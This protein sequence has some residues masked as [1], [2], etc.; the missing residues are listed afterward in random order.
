MN[1]SRLFL[2]AAL[3]AGLVYLLDADRGRRR[4]ALLRDKL[5]RAANV[6]Y[7]AVDTTTRDMANRSRGIVAV[8]RSRFRN[9]PVSDAVLTERVRSKLGRWTSHPGAIELEARDGHVTLRGPVLTH[10]VP[11]LLAAVGA[12]RG[13]ESVADQLELHDTADSVPALQGEGTIPGSSLDLLQRTWAPAT[14]AL[15]AAAGLAAT[16]LCLAI[17][18]RRGQQA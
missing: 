17:Y 1:N 4:R 12:V 13:V 11:A 16:G 3:G 2:G 14:Q 9:E 7:D 18:N 10:E 6:T 15:V 5:V 8:T